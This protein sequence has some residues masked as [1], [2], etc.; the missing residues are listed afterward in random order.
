MQCHWHFWQMIS[1]NSFLVLVSVNCLMYAHPE[2][3]HKADGNDLFASDI[4]LEL[5]TS[6]CLQRVLQ[7]DYKLSLPQA[8]FLYRK[9]R[10]WPSSVSV[11]RQLQTNSFFFSTRTKRSTEF[12][13][14]KPIFRF[15]S[16]SS[17]FVIES[18]KHLRQ[19]C[20]LKFLS[21]YSSEIRSELMWYLL[22]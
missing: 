19:K 21:F 5:K 17:F 12:K 13:K 6:A 2:V 1:R 10:S 11:A 15:K 3:L 14:R 22:S 8:M 9:K 18:C 4:F 20:N 16:K 7:F